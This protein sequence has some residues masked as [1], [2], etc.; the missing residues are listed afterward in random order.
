MASTAAARAGQT[1][2]RN[3]EQT[4]ENNRS[5]VAANKKIDLRC[6][7]ENDTDAK[8]EEKRKKAR[9]SEL[10]RMRAASLMA[11][12]RELAS[13]LNSEMSMWQKEFAEVKESPE[14]RKLSIQTRALALRDARETERRK[15]ADEMYKLQWQSSCDDGRLLDSKATIKRVMEDREN[16]MEQ[17]REINI[18]L[19]QEDDMLMDEWRQRIEEL[20]IKENE[21]EA[22]RRGMEKEIKGMLDEQVEAH[23]G[24]KE[25]L[26]L[27]KE[28]DAAEELAEWKNAKE[29]EDAEEQERFT[30]SK[31]RGKAT[32][33]FNQSR[34][35]IRKEASDRIKSED[36]LLLNY[37]LN[38]ER[39]AEASEQHKK[40]MEKETTKRYQA[41][42]KAQMLK[43]QENQS[44]IDQL[45]KIEEDKIWSKREKEQQDRLDT[46]N[47]LWN[48]TD[49]GRQEQIR[50][51]KEREAKLLDDEKIEAHAHGGNQNELDKIEANKV[52]ARKEAV[53]LNQMA[54]KAQGAYSQRLIRR[55]TQEKFLDGKIMNKVEMEHKARLS[56][57]AGQVKVNFPNKHTQWYS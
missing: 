15:F 37:A 7:W 12:K 10:M 42:L 54:V 34:L 27:R 48:E 5:Y 21:K 51:L 41:Y 3:L 35:N 47:K 55:E 1:R 9:V 11:R 39:E 20:E 22:Y 32:R 53:M 14:D 28:A 13:K 46:R 16:Q 6:K 23:Q 56:E 52:A 18:K 36:L 45:R 57:M 25:A 30:I 26:R 4:L 33:D 24:R 43:E 2:S 17:K 49:K 8:L 40:D 19:Q 31:Q 44:S 29:I 50:M 38:K